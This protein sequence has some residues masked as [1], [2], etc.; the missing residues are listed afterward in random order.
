MNKVR[1][2]VLLVLV[3]TS[4]GVIAIDY[5]LDFKGMDASLLGRM[6]CE[7]NT[8]NDVNYFYSKYNSDVARMLHHKFN[9]RAGVLRQNTSMAKG[10]MGSF[11]NL[12]I[13][14]FYPGQVDAD[15]FVVFVGWPE[16]GD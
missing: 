12:S 3:M 14:N 7:C 10:F 15:R 4:F 2:Y 8:V 9:Q 11:N 6:G 16:F 1:V 13:Y 5:S